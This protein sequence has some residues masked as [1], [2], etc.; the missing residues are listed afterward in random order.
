MPES[1]QSVKQLG[2]VKYSCLSVGL[3]IK[4][5]PSKDVVVD[6]SSSLRAYCF[7]LALEITVLSESGV[8]DC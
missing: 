2:Q 6:E 1:K 5:L 3:S 4:W 7:L 8:F